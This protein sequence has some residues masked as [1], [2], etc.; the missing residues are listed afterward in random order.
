MCLGHGLRQPRPTRRRDPQREIHRGRVR[1]LPGIRD[2]RRNLCTSVAGQRLRRR[3]ADGNRQP[4]DVCPCAERPFD[5][6][7]AR[8]HRQ[9]VAVLC[10]PSATATMLDA[11]ELELYKRLPGDLSILTPSPASDTDTVTVTGATRQVEPEDDR[12]PGRAFGG[13]EV[14]GALGLP[15]P[16]VGAAGPASRSTGSTSA[17]ATSWRSATAAAR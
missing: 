1:R 17:P 3:T 9:P 5:R 12:R 2:H 4:R 6:P 14:R 13:R 7:G 15:G 11:V 8:V 10:S 16:A